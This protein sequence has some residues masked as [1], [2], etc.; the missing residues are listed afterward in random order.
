LIPG[1][2]I[3]STGLKALGYGATALTAYQGVRALTGGDGGATGGG[4]SA[5]MI[6]TMGKRSIFRDDPNV[7]EHLKQY[8]ISERFLKTFYRA[9]KGAII[10]R[11]EV[12]KPYGLPKNVAKM[13]GMWKPAKKPPISV[14]AWTAFQHSKHVM[15]QLASIHKEGQK[16]AHFASMGKR[17]AVPTSYQVINESGPG[18]VVAFPKRKSA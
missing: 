9:P 10:L 13:Y 3:V 17:R 6:A 8:A 5:P 16:F 12:G 14:T 7:H 2:G 4:A 18:S 15:K 11:D 1:G